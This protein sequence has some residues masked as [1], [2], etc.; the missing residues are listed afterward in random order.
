[1][2]KENGKHQIPESLHHQRQGPWN[3]GQVAS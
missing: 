1:M 3:Q 2:T